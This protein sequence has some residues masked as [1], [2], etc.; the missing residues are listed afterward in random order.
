MRGGE[1]SN[2]E[3]CLFLF[4]SVSNVQNVHSRSNE[5][6]LADIGRTFFNPRVFLFFVWCISVGIGIS[7]VVNFLFWYLEELSEESVMQCEGTPANIKTLQGLVMVVQTFGGEVP[8]FFL[9]GRVFKLIGYAHSMSLVLGGYALRFLLYSVLT[10]VWWVLPIE[11]LQGVTFGIFMSA[12]NTYAHMM[13]PIGTE[14]T[15]QV[16]KMADGYVL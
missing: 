3:S 8:M 14:A 1:F 9:S 12:M 11:L 15:L 6:M 16:I 10:N 4:L 5:T 7:L 13:A 2:Q